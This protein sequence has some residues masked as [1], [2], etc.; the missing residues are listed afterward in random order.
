VKQA[1]VEPSTRSWAA[2]DFQSIAFGREGEILAAKVR[3]GIMALIGLIPVQTVLF[4]AASAEAKIALGAT[5]LV[6][7]FGTVVLKVAQ[8]TKPPA[9]LGLVTSL[10]DVSTISLVNAGFLLSGNPLA[11]T[12]S[13]VVFC[14]YFVALALVCLRQ[15][16]RWCLIAAAVAMMEY[17]CIVAWASARYDLSTPR[18]RRV[19]TAGSTGT[20]RSHV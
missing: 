15:D 9:W 4:R 7:A 3:L 19:V 14:C 8:R 16:W 13:R 12:N 20:I 18:L 17:A 11:V 5:I 10:L 6:L 1:A 2:P